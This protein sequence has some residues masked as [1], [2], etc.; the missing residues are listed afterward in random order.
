[1]SV[2]YNYAVYFREHLDPESG[3]RWL[4]DKTA[5]ETIPVLTEAV[6][7]LGTERAGGYWASTPGNTGHALSVL[8]GWATANP[9]ARWEVE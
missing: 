6:R 1:M 7:L 4:H 3:L 2:T 5:A 8:L 9:D